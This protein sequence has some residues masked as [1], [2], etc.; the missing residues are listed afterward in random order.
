M[1]ILV[2]HGESELNARNCLVGRLDPA[3]TDLGKRQAQAAGATLGVVGELLV[4]PLTRTQQTAV[5]LNTSCEL[6]T[7]ERVIEVDYGELDGTPLEAIESSL[8]ERWR[9][10]PTF[11][12]PRGESLATLADRITPVM[13]EMF[14]TPG[15]RA[16]SRDH[17]VVIVSHV[18]PI[19]AC[20]AWALEADPLL[21]WRLRLSTGSITRIAFGP[22]GPQ[23]LGFNEVPDLL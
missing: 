4:S 3:L 18:S 16:R 9:T 17:D 19:K 10:D 14:S 22:A 23:L 12:P 21:A 20:V 15:E 5:L 7:D 2:R 6:A 11:A 8:W 1:L 13:E